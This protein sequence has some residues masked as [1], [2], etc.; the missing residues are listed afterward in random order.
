MQKLINKEKIHKILEYWYTIE[1][2]G[3]DNW[4]SGREYTEKIKNHK[5]SLAKRKSVNT[6]QLMGFADITNAEI[7]PIVSGQAKECEMNCWG[8]ITVYL[9]KIKREVCIK[10]LIARLDIKED[11][12]P[13]TSVDC[14]ALASFQVTPDGNYIEDS[15]SLSPVLWALTQIKDTNNIANSINHNLYSSDIIEL[16]HILAPKKSEN[17]PY[18]IFAVDMNRLYTA[19]YEQ[20]IQGILLE[21]C[22]ELSVQKSFVLM[23]QMFADEKAKSRYEDDTYTGLSRDYFSKDIKIIMDEN[24]YGNLSETMQNYI[25]AL[26]KRYIGEEDK[27]RIDVVHNDNLEKYELQLNHILRMKNAPIGKWPSKYMPALMQQVAINLLVGKDSRKMFGENGSV[28]SVNGPPGT[29]KT[30]LLKEVVV[31]NIVERAVLLAE[32]DHPDDAFSKQNF[33]N[34]TKPEHAYSKYVRHWYRL[35]D[36]R[37]N[38]YSILVA[39]CNNAAVEN[40]S[41]ELPVGKGILDD[42]TVSDDEPQI[43]GKQLNEVR[44]LFDVSKSEDIENLFAWDMKKMEV[45]DIYFTDYANELLNIDNA[46]GLIAAPLGKKSNKKSF[47]YKVLYNLLRDFYQKNETVEKRVSQYHEARD[48]FMKQ[49]R[50]VTMMQLQLDSYG[51]ISEKRIV[52]IRKKK[53]II[54]KYNILLADENRK[55]TILNHELKKI[56]EEITSQYCVLAE[57]KQQTETKELEMQKLEEMHQSLEKQLI[58]IREKTLSV[59][60]STGLFAKLFRTQ[61]HK[62]TMKLAELYRDKGNQ[63]E[64]L[65]SE[66]QAKRELVREKLSLFNQEYAD[67]KKQMDAL[68]NDEE[69]IRNQLA[70]SEKRSVTFNIQIEQA[71]ADMEAIQ[72]KYTA[73]ICELTN[74]TI[75]KSGVALDEKYIQRIFSKD[76][77]DSTGAEVENP[78]ATQLYNREREKLFYYAIKLNKEFILSSKSC[79]DN[80]KSLG[81]YWGYKMGDDN[82]VIEFRE[83]MESGFVTALI[84]TLFLLVPVISTTFASVNSFFRDVKQSGAVGLLVVDEAG[85]AQ[86]QMALGALYRS[87]K[88]MIVGDPKQVEPIVTDELKLLKET[89]QEELYHPYKEKNVSVQS[90]ADLMNPFG[91]FM[92]NGSDNPDWVGCPL[93]VHRRCISPMYEISNTISYN[94][95]MKQQTRAPKHEVVQT[96]IYDKSQWIN[97]VGKEQGKKKH[98]VPAQGEKV[99]EMLEVAFGKNESPDIFIISPFTTVVRGMREYILSYCKKHKDSPIQNALQEWIYRNIG[100][101]HTFQGKEAKEVIFLLGCDSSKEAS[102]AISWVNKNIVNVAVT[103]AKYRLYIIGDEKAWENSECVG[104]AQKMIKSI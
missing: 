46:W 64:S 32:Y 34:G 100:T 51:E 86:P 81:H 8:N 19:I 97:V 95:M 67:F 24:T 94:G 36:D 50:I 7:M 92:D 47:Y 15:L 63:L 80:F 28:F 43:I 26:Y 11:S 61:K 14:I 103:R 6:K 44:D 54:N 60:N 2:L 38:N 9:G 39:S 40:I 23:Y 31:N 22:G 72:Q 77:D 65:I 41:K 85:Q 102:G 33:Q 96:F 21:E 35:K 53:E 20:Y 76:T 1:F 79:R 84:Q 98:F 101:V 75:D 69:H 45:S 3:Q 55:L 91:T 70:D 5:R 30:T 49:Y 83:S 74:T 57:M 90:C 78:W 59:Q 88:A 71:Q 48:A 52:E 99:C 89:Y 87:R 27:N 10:E 104:M 42:L 37:I 4:P 93:L 73:K 12:R 29:G 25:L 68:K 16:E 17:E 18:K 56:V 13:E 82:E 62:D 58:E 66:N